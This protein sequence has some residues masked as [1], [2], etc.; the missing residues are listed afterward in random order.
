MLNRKRIWRLQRQHPG[1]LSPSFG[2]KNGNVWGRDCATPHPPSVRPKP[3]VTPHPRD[4]N[5]RNP[6]PVPSLDVRACRC[7][8]TNGVDNATRRME[9]G[10]GCRVGRLLRSV[11]NGDAFFIAFCFACELNAFYWPKARPQMLRKQRRSTGG[12]WSW[13]LGEDVGYATPYQRLAERGY[14]VQDPVIPSFCSH[15]MD[16]MAVPI[17]RTSPRTMNGSQES[18][19]ERES[20]PNFRR[21]P[22]PTSH[23]P[24]CLCRHNFGYFRNK[25]PWTMAALFDCV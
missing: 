16:I 18:Q 23:T 4:P 9:G 12:P 19:T 11:L 6:I 24:S 8:W 2:N 20:W 22:S 15:L 3:P 13:I 10:T 7:L 25:T 5:P 17:I 1:P 21:P 14:W